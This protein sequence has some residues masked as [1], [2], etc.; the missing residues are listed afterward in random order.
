[1]SSAPLTLKQ[2]RVLGGLLRLDPQ[3]RGKW[4]SWPEINLLG[5]S[6]PTLSSMVDRGLIDVQIRITDAGAFAAMENGVMKRR[7]D[8]T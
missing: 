8:E 2:S 5:R 1:M 3:G 4:S 6:G 7:S